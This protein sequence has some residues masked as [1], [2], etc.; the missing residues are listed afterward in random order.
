[1]EFNKFYGSNNVT[2]L[3][4]IIDTLLPRVVEIIRTTLKDGLKKA[5]WSERRSAFGIRS[6]YALT[7]ERDGF[8]EHLERVKQKQE[9]QKLRKQMFIISPIDPNEDAKTQ[10]N[11]EMEYDRLHAYI[12]ERPGTLYTVVF[13]LSDEHLSHGGNIAIKVPEKEHHQLPEGNEESE[14]LE[15]IDAGVANHLH[16]PIEDVKLEARSALIIPGGNKFGFE[17]THYG[18]R[19]YLVVEFWM[20]QDAYIAPSRLSLREGEV[21]GAIGHKDL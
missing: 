17:P 13:Q 7:A 10:Q 20:Y 18:Q 6:V 11:W 1:M 9:E 5:L 15:E 19:S 14:E 3:T 2:F 12:S 8:E 21:L 4:G 16:R